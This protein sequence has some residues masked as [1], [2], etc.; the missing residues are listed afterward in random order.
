MHVLKAPRLSETLE[1]LKTPAIGGLVIV[2]PF[3]IME[4]VNLRKLGTGFPVV[5]FLVMW[6]LALSFISILMPIL[7][8]VPAGNQNL[9][10]PISLF[11]RIALLI[12]IGW[13]WG[14][15]VLDQ[16]PCFLGVPNCD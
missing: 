3:M 1:N 4:L 15:I 12:L 14:S 6:I 7:R 11:P 9:W 16:M 8:S 13:L 2:F 10:S 5:L